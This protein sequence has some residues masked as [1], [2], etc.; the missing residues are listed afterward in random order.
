[1]FNHVHMAELNAVKELYN[2][3][4]YQNRIIQIFWN[5]AFIFLQITVQKVQVPDELKSELEISKGYESNSHEILKEWGMTRIWNTS[6][7]THPRVFLCFSLSVTS[8]H[9]AITLPTKNLVCLYIIKMGELEHSWDWVA[10]KF[11]HWEKTHDLEYT[12]YHLKWE[13][14]PLVCKPL[15]KSFWKHKAV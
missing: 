11:F 6:F 10:D 12:A 15:W 3:R 14:N 4:L 1:M 5:S 13:K 8:I 7:P 2:L 9:V